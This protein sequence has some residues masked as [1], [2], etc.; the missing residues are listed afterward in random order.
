MSVLEKIYTVEQNFGG[1][2]RTVAIPVSPVSANQVMELMSMDSSPSDFRIGVYKRV[3][4]E[5]SGNSPL[6]KDRIFVG[7]LS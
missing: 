1:E 5:D 7:A 3:D 2:W 6:P 4:R